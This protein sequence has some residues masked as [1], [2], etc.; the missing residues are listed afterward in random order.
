MRDRTKLLSFALCA[1]LMLGFASTVQAQI[2]HT[3][4]SNPNEVVQYVNTELMGEFR[5]S[6]ANTGAS[7][8]IGSTITI[9]YQ[10]VSITNADPVGAA[11]SVC[12][13]D[14]IASHP[15]RCADVGSPTDSRNH[16]ETRG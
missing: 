6:W 2:Q 4:S 15:R 5:L 3:V 8:V 12:R 11:M 16:R 1:L 9:T 13:P 10:G 7:G 14:R